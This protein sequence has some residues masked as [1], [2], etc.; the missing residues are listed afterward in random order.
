VPCTQCGAEVYEDAV[1]CP[2]CGAYLTQGT[3]PWSPRPSWRTILV[4][5]GI[6]AAILVVLRCSTG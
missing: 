3:H 5:S 4:L 2:T 6:L 1:Q